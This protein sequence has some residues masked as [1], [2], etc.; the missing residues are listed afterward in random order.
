MTNPAVSAVSTDL[1]SVRFRVGLVR[2]QWRV[3]SY[4]F[5][6]LIVGVAAVEPDGG[7]SEYTFRFELAGF[8]GA[9]PAVQIWDVGAGTT[10]ALEK[11][12]KGSARVVAAFKDWPPSQGI[13]RPW[14]RAAGPHFGQ[15]H[16]SLAWHPKRDLAFVME[17]L[18]GLL[19]SNAAKRSAG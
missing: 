19:T 16:P 14:E 1:A 2:G 17:D 7:A 18:H 9:A 8:P 11:R 5:P 6:L 4:E 12:P 13:Y 10:L 3:I 15:P